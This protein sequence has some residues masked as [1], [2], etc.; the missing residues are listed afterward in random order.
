MLKDTI[1]AADSINQRNILTI[2]ISARDSIF[3]NE[4]T[5][6]LEDLKKTVFNFITDKSDSINSPETEKTDI[7]GLGIRTVLNTVIVFLSQNSASYNMYMEVQ[8]EI[9]LAFTAARNQIAVEEY[10]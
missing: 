9:N 6:R 2:E 10:G 1:D 8:N 4:K 3:A 5:I 7:P